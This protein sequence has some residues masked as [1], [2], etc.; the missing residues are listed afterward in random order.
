M[1]KKRRFNPGRAALRTARQQ[2]YSPTVATKDKLRKQEAVKQDSPTDQQ[3]AS[4]QQSQ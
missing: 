3:E 1:N 4:Q 2:A